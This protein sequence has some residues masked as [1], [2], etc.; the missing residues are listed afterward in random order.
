MMQL[1]TR[2]VTSDESLQFI[3]GLM[4]CGRNGVQFHAHPRKHLSAER[5][6]AVLHRLQLYAHQV[7]FHFRDFSHL[8]AKPTNLCLL[9]YTKKRML[10]GGLPVAHVFMDVQHINGYDSSAPNYDRLTVC[11]LGRNIIRSAVVLC[12]EL[13]HAIAYF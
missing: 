12:H 8:A 2:I 13:A 3:S 6:Q 10:P 1:A 7:A 4:D 5:K 9:G 11:D